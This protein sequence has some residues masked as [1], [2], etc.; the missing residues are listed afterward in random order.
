M[1]LAERWRQH[2]ADNRMTWSQHARFAAGHG[3]TC[4][5][6]GIA[7]LVH[8]AAPCWCQTAGRR[9]R[10]ALAEGFREGGSA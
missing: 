3:V 7:L 6:S 2:L 1:T 9:A 10:K 5:L 8:A 4:L